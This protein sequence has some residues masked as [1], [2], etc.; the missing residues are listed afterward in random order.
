[1]DIVALSDIFLDKF[2]SSSVRDIALK[3]NLDDELK[4]LQESVVDIRSKCFGENNDKA[5]KML[6]DLLYDAEDIFDECGFYTLKSQQ[7]QNHHRK[8][9][10]VRHIFYKIRSFAFR[11]KMV[12]EMQRLVNRLHKIEMYGKPRNAGALGYGGFRL[13]SLPPS[14]PL[15]FDSLGS[16]RKSKK[17]SCANELSA[18]PSFDRGELLGAESGDAISATTAVLNDFAEIDLCIDY[19]LLEEE[20]VDIAYDQANDFIGVQVSSV[21]SLRSRESKRTSSAGES[22]V[23]TV[24]AAG[25]LCDDLG[26]ADE[27]VQGESSDAAYLLERVK[28][29]TLLNRG[30]RQN[31]K[32][33]IVE[34]L[35]ERSNEGILSV[36]PI[37]GVGGMGK[38]TL[39]KL[40]YNDERVVKHFQLRIWV[41]V[42]PC[43]SVRKVVERII[44]SAPANKRMPFRNYEM[45]ELRI[46][47]GDILCK[48]VYLLVLDGVWNE[49]EG[50]WNQLKDFLVA[51]AK[52]SKIVVTTRDESVALASAIGTM[53]IYCVERLANDDCLSLFLK[54]AF[55][56]GQ[57]EKYPNLV[58]I[59]ADIVQKCEGVPLGVILLGS[60]LR[61]RTR[62]IEWTDIRDH[63]VWDSQENGKMFPVL[64]LSYEKLPS[65]LKACLAYCLIFP[66]G[67]EIEIDKLIQ[68]WISQGLIHTS[69]HFEEPEEIGLEYFN[70][71]SF[72]SFFQDIEENG[73][74]FGSICKMNDTVHDFLL[75]LAGSEC[76]TVYAHTQNISEDVK[77]VAF[78]DYDESGKQLPTSLLQN[79]GLRTIFFPVDELGPTSTSFVDNCVSRFMH[80]RTLDLS[81]SSFEMLPSSIGELKRLKYFDLSS[82]CSIQTVPNSIGKLHCLLILR[83]A[84]CTQLTELPKDAEDLISLRHLYLTTKQESFPDRSVGCLSSLRSLSLYSCKNLVSLSDELKHL[85]NLR[86]LTIVDCPKLT[87]LPSSMKYLTALENLYIIDCDE[88][89]L[90]EWQDIE[91]IKMVRSLVIGGL[92]ELSSKDVQCFENLKSFVIDGLANLVVLPRWLEGSALTLRNLRIARCP[93]FLELPEWLKNLTALESIQIAE[94]PRLRSLPAG[95]HRLTELKE[96][97]ID[98]CPQLSVVCGEEDRAKIA[99]IKETY[100]DGILQ[101]QK[102]Q[103]K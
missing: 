52:G 23:A 42:S 73:L 3:W 24:G 65:Y 101:V 2:S 27:C 91:G 97:K 60:S 40:V 12:Y 18:A 53:P 70:Q 93:N 86:T 82:N 51:G 95:M 102:I 6:R 11:V 77:H 34:A 84:L 5:A 64:K 75:S 98:N 99:H 28:L 43:F 46:V 41:N 103:N 54:R 36:L 90:F 14:P 63:S 4:K 19:D 26:F 16:S 44:Q 81:H 45:D 61:G 7:Q 31:D 80:L 48:K 69:T 15:S 85:R 33:R 92:P 37:V 66:K 1:M 49:Y 50:K 67:C 74:F 96:L 78:S 9:L 68:L 25:V 87:F 83:A 94:C 29:R 47:V 56:E 35:M 58:R 89:T 17:T 72:K 8:L 30:V 20:Y 76:S 22:S 79:H 13:G 38:S 100:L 39:V 32:D 88:L 62:E 71:L 57:E 55:E 21:E 10:Q 59:G